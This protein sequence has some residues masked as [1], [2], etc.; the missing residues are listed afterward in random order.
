[1]PVK[2]QK[3]DS[4]NATLVATVERDNRIDS[5]RGLMLIL[6]AINHFGGWVATLVWEPL[7]FVSD[8]E[9]FIFISGFVLAVVYSRYL[10]D[11][12]TF[13]KKI[14]HRCWIIYK[15]HLFLLVLI[16]VVPFFFPVFKTI[17]GQVVG[18]YF[19]HSLLKYC[20]S[21]LLFFYQPPFMD[22]L[23][24]YVIC[25][26]MSLP[27]LILLYKGKDLLVIMLSLIIWVAGQFFN[28]ISF[29]G[30]HFFNGVTSGYFN[31]FSWQI[32]FFTGVYFGYKT[33]TGQEVVFLKSKVVSVTLLILFSAFLFFRYALR[34]GFV[35]LADADIT[36]FNR[37][38]MSWLRV[39]NF[40][41]VVYAIS[42]MLKKVPKK[43]K[44][45]GFAF[46]GKHSLQVFS[47]HIAIIYL[48]LYSM[49]GGAYLYE[50][51]GNII[52]IPSLLLFV[53]LLFIPAILHSLYM[54]NISRKKKS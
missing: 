38:E 50:R 4:L 43:Y 31:I 40:F 2:D 33:K 21:T 6:L 15:Y 53:V 27:I 45:P 10:I 17:W 49:V 20:V 41:V 24:I 13:V 19:S 8:A 34:F 51:Y 48:F 16:P 39:I 7:G 35:E 18:Y 30:N 1:M 11:L 3:L 42:L 28:P 36:I 54:K 9:G 23:P 46:L 12:K 25:A 44:I 14:L 52:Y 32:I 22:V 37:G 26:F 29:L 47:F 5:I